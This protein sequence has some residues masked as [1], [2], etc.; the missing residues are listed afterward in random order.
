MLFVVIVVVLLYFLIKTILLFTKFTKC[1]FS[2]DSFKIFATTIEA[3]NMV[4]ATVM[5][6]K[7]A[8]DNERVKSVAAVA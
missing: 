7:N 5:A 2:A 3:K 6:L 4:D 1:F 8:N